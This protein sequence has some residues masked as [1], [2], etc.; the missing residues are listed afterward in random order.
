MGLS[1]LWER[2]ILFVQQEGGEVLEQAKCFWM[3]ALLDWH[4]YW[5]SV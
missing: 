2:L 1:A 3:I 5:D 4:V